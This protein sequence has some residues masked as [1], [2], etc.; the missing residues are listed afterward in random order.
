[1]DNTQLA[2]ELRTWL[3]KQKAMTDLANN[4]DRVGALEKMEAD[5]RAKIEEAKSAVEAEHAKL[6][7]ARA[8][9][10]EAQARARAAQEDASQYA[11]EIVEAD[12][13]AQAMREDATREAR[14]IVDEAKQ[15]GATIESAAK[16]EAQTI[17]EQ[18]GDQG[19]QLK[20]LQGNILKAREEL[21]R[22][23]AKI[24][25]AKERARRSFAA[26]IG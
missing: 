21:G 3:K 4:L 17:R 16:R 9:A 15:R 2:N 23:E 13:H 18:I 26:E 6:A 10:E 11:A 19:R 24:E 14:A 5:T 20:L 25:Q 1:M 7:D 8:A 22:T 12:R